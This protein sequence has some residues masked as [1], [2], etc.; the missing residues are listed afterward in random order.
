MLL[1]MLVAR[2]GGAEMC[3]RSELKPMSADHPECLFY[4]GTERYRARD[5]AA[6]GTYW[7]RLVDLPDVLFE[8]E[9]LRTSAFNNLG[10]LYSRGWGLAKDRDRAIAHWKYAAKLGHEESAYHLCRAIS[11]PTES[12]FEL[13]GALGYCRESL[14][15]YRLLADQD[16]ANRDS[17]AELNARIARLESK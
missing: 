16:K 10:Y 15:R 6:A 7:Q 1:L 8:H 13:K 2:A 5:Y 14:R 4:S 3:T 17:I 9:Y 11:D 12:T